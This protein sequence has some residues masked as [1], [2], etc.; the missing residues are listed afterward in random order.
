[1]VV[2]KFYTDREEHR[3]RQR[4]MEVAA[5]RLA[6]QNYHDG[7]I[8]EIA[9]STGFPIERVKVYFQTSEDVVLALY[10]RF[11]NDLESRIIDLPEGTLSERFRALM[12]IKFEITEPYRKTLAGLGRKLLSRKSKV[13]VLSS[14]TEMIRERVRSV[15]TQTI[16][17]ATN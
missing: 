17:G 15:L 8:D 1:M 11:A 9:A 10:S 14:E 2:Q 3:I 13:G 12:E 5:V 4:F 7:L 16:V 6:R